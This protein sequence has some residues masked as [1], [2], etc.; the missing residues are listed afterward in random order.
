MVIQI[1]VARA[2]MIIYMILR[3]ILLQITVL[4]CCLNLIDKKYPLVVHFGIIKSLN[5]AVFLLETVSS[6]NFSSLIK[7]YRQNIWKI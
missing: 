5:L 2:Y 7:L 3:N 6:S 4:C 1:Y